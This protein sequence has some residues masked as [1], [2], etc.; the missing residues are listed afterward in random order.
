M[1][2]LFAFLPLT[3]MLL[4]GVAVAVA[5]NSASEK[6]TALIVREDTKNV[7]KSTGIYAYNCFT[8]DDLARFRESGRVQK[9]TE[10]LKSD[11]QF[12][13]AVAAVADLSES[14]RTEVLGK[15]RKIA[16]PTYAMTGYIDPSGKSQT[17]AGRTAQLEIAAAI[18]DALQAAVAGTK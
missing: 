17:D 1:R 8:D 6:L 16:Q 4:A 12:K 15:A 9:I 3:S 2:K 14:A 5:Q 10:G 13:A 7:K 18:C 11:A